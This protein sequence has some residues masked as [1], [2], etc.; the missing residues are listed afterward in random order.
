MSM[1]P[2]SSHWADQAA[3]RVVN[4][5]GE[6][7]QYVAASGITPS[8][9]VHIGNFRE[10]I[11]VDFVARALKALGKKVRTIHSWDDFDTFRKVPVNLPNQEMLTEHLRQPI[12]LVPDPYGKEKSYAAS[13]CKTFEKDLADV[14]IHPIFIYQH[15]KYQSGEYA[16][17]MRQ[18]LQG[19]D[20]VV[21]ILNKYRGNPLGSDWLPTT[22]YCSNCKKD[23]MYSQSY[24]GDWS[25]SYHCK[26]CDQKETLNIKDAKYLKLNWRTDWPMRWAFEGVDFEPGGKDHSSEGGSFDTARQIVKDV[27]GKN[28]PIYQPYDFVMVKGGTGKMSSSKGELLT[29]GAALK[30]YSPEIVR[31][32]FANQ[33]PNTDFSIAFDEDVIKLYDEFDRFEVTA[34]GPKPETKAEKWE[35]ARRTYQLSSLDDKLLTAIPYRAPFRDLTGRLQICDGDITRTM[36]K[37]YAEHIKTPAD[38]KSFQ[39]RAQCALNW[40]EDYAPESFCYAIHKD[41]VEMSL[42]DIQTSALEKLRELVSKTDLEGVDPKVLNQS[43]YDDVIRGAGIDGKVFFLTVY[44]KLIGREQGPRLPSFLKEIGR[45]RLLHLL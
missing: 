25:Y 7:D 10:A 1:Q 20:K 14:G 9:V 33:R 22:I 32:I 37:F 4:Q 15:E 2:I 43:I 28:P 41:P 5:L 26:S 36:K 8:G 27:W 13:G 19:R 23:E 12:C 38:E 45:E 39:D 3:A 34:H 11:T 17:S 44:M 6:K 35:T 16:E 18:A 42:D 24:D 40:L 30:V 21:A 31:W 29:V